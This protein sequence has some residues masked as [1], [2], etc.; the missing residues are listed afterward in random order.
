[1]TVNLYDLPADGTQFTTYCGGNLTGDNESC[2]EVGALTGADD[3]YVL[4]DNKPGGPGTQLRFTGEE[5]DSFARSWVEKRNL[6]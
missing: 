1:M 6:I 2:I 4:Q 3:A 5:L